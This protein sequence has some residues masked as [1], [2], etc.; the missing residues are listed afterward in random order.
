MEKIIHHHRGDSHQQAHGR[1]DQSFS[2][3][4]HYRRTAA[5]FQSQ[6]LEGMNDAQEMYQKGR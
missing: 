4:G 3:T 5:A 2:N 1:S 6:I